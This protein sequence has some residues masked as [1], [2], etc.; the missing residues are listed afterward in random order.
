MAA[1]TSRTRTPFR[2]RT[3]LVALAFASSVAA[4]AQ[5]RPASPTPDAAPSVRSSTALA[6][7]VPATNPM[8]GT[9][10]AATKPRV[11]GWYVPWDRR[12]GLR[13]ITA[14][15]DVIGAVSPFWYEL[16]P[17]GRV[18]VHR[19]TGDPALLRLARQRQ[20]VLTPTISNSYRPERVAWILRHPGRRATHI[21]RL[22][23]L[24]DR[25]MY[26]GLDVDYEN[27]APRDRALF[28]RFVTELG[29]ALHARGKTL[30]VTVMPKTRDNV[31]TGPSAAIDYAAIGRVADQ[32][33]VMAYDYHWRCGRSGPIAPLPWVESV[34]RYSA[35]RIEP[36][37]LVLGV[38][39]YA[40]RWPV[41]GCG[42]ARTWQQVARERRN[43]RAK[44]GFSKVWATA[45]LR[46]G[47]HTT[48]Y[49]D[50]RSIRAKAMIAQ[51]Y[52]LAGV[53]AWRFGEED[54]AIFRSLVAALGTPPAAPAPL[55][56]PLVP[57]PAPPVP[58]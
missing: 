31:R 11:G 18:I 33:R 3:A 50:A 49:E 6:P 52:G 51:R 1:Q 56:D 16:G 57:V 42:A 10:E 19:T 36:S 9:P 54:P 41:R 12:G 27:V 30:S 40:Y 20:I 29:A 39:F 45:M 32:V 35:S 17:R 53:Y 24:V 26:A 23:R 48:W 34:V 7:A 5:A 38:P 46:V 14:N 2:G 4:V 22:V 44:N 21:T 28:T 15:A 37:K 58:G 55:P 47:R 13:T 43:P 8:Y 25:P